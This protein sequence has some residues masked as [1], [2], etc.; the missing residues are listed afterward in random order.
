V[1]QQTQGLVALKGVA[2]LVLLLKGLAGLVLSL[3]LAA[4]VLTLVTIQALR[5]L[6]LTATTP[7]V[8]LKLY[9]EEALQ[10]LSTKKDV[11]T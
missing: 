8:T 4:A 11:L 7:E 2:G 3:F 10:G 6:V 9:L 1:Q 5:T